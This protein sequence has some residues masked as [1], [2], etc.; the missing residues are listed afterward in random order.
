MREAADPSSGRARNGRPNAQP[1]C[2]DPV[3]RRPAYAAHGIAASQRSRLVCLVVVT[4]WICSAFMRVNYAILS[5]AI[6]S[7]LVLLFAIGGLPQ[8]LVALH[9]VEA[10]LLGGAIALSAQ[11]LDL[12]VTRI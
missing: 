9:R 6:T 12:W 11:G 10:T 2:R 3:R 1:A 8:P 4:A 5:L 7:Y